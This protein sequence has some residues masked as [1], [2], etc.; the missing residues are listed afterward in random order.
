MHYVKGD[1]FSMRVN[2]RIKKFGYTVFMMLAET[3]TLEGITSLL[4]NG[5]HNPLFDIEKRNPQQPE[6]EFLEQVINALSESQTKYW[7]PDIF[8]VSDNEG[9]YRAWCFAEVNF[10]DYLR[11]QLDL[12]DAGILD[13]NFFWWTVKQGKA[14]LRL[15]EKKNRPLQQTVNV[16]KSYSVPIPEIGSRERVIYDTGIK[17]RGLTIFLGENGKIIFGDN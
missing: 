1:V 10:T 2:L 11:M 7:L 16:L 3:Q 12:L 13:Y 15:S 8:L 5:K 6:K 9:S 4:P 17:K 14:T